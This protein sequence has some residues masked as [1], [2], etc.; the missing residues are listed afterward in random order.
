MGLVV[1]V[2]LGDGDEG[3]A[4]ARQLVPSLP[5]FVDRQVGGLDGCL[6]SGRSGCG[7]PA[8]E[9][10][11]GHCA[12]DLAALVATHAVGDAED[13]AVDHDGVLVDLAELADVG[14]RSDPEVEDGHRSSS[15]VE[16][17][18]TRSPRFITIGPATLRRLR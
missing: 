13:A 7:H 15:T 8:S 9:D 10:L 4:H 11:D 2:D 18:C 6:E 17:I 5:L 12:G 16:P 1:D 3:G 14:G